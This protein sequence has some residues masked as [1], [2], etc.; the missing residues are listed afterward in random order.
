MTS[1]NEV[2][3]DIEVEG[4]AKAERQFGR[5]EKGARGLGRSTRGLINPLLGAGLVAGILGGG[6]LGLALSSG[7]ASNS[8]FRIQGAMEGL[9]GTITR[10][11]EPA[12]DRAASFFEKLPVAAQLGVVATA[13]ILGVVFVKLIGI[14]AGKIAVAISTHIGAAITSTI[15][16]L[17]AGL[18]AAAAA[19]I[20]AVVVGLAS[21]ALIAW[22]LIFNNG[23]LLKRFEAWLSGMGWIQAIQKWDKE[24]LTPFFTNAWNKAI[25]IFE[26]SFRDPFVAEWEALRDSFKQDFV[27]TFTGSQQK[28]SSRR[29]HFT[30]T[31]PNAFKA[32]WDRGISIFRQFFIDIFLAAWTTAKG[33]L[34]KRRFTLGPF[35]TETIPG[36]IH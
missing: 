7:S 12:I 3:I 30:E 8:I 31:I 35:F 19:A 15:A 4:G 28:S 6:L 1:R 36:H 23:A 16:P 17:V 9:I 34:S 5:A 14:A 20:S 26:T 33:L 29:L 24:V 13:A 27:G 11:L 2:R 18:T 32:G 25:G 10:S 22:D 21:L